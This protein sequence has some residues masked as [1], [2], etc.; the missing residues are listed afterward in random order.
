MPAPVRDL[1]STVVAVTGASSGIGAA[2][3]RLLVEAGALVALGA[4]RTERL[5]AL[6]AELGSSRVFAAPLDVRD[7]RVSGRSSR[8]WW[9]GSAGWTA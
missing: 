7:P 8:R 2:T 9:S 3:A 4:R 1:S 5:E 6:E